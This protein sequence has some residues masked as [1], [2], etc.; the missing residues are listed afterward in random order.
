MKEKSQLEGGYVGKRHSWLHKLFSLI[1]FTF[2]LM[3]FLFLLDSITGSIFEPSLVTQSSSMPEKNSSDALGDDGSKNVVQMYRRLASMASSAFVERE[4]K[5]NESKFWK[6]SYWQASVWSPCADRKG[7]PRA[8][9]KI[10]KETM[11][12]SWLAQMAV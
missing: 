6:E 8:G 3:G 12:I 10:F 5:K 11:V 7:L 1:V 9:Q 2:A 4:L